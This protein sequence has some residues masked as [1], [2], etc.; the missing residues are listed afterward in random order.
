MNT[1]SVKQIIGTLAFGIFLFTIISLLF[2]D[3]V[4]L[5]ARIAVVDFGDYVVEVRDVKYSD[6][7]LIFS[8][9]IESIEP[10][11]IFIEPIVQP[12]VTLR[13]EQT[14]HVKTIGEHKNLYTDYYVIEAAELP[15]TISVAINVEDMITRTVQLK[16]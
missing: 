2:S 16:R 14:I 9:L 3:K 10:R 13:K 6:Q 11:E 15:E 7:Y 1:L 5:D 8:Y 4:T 12:A